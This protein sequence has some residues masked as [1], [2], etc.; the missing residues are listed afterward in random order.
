MSSKPRIQ[1]KAVRFAHDLEL[2]EGIHALV[3]LGEE[4]VLLEVADEVAGLARPEE[5]VPQL[6]HFHGGMPLRSLLRDYSTRVITMIQFFSQVP[7]ASGE[8]ACSQRA[9]V[10]VILDHV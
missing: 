7:P 9:P 8:K 1:T 10:F 6:E 2:S 5:V 4:E 3:P